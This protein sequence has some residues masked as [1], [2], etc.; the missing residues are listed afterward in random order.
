VQGRYSTQADQV[1]ED[2]Q[3]FIKHDFDDRLTLPLWIP[4][5]ITLGSV[6]Y[7]RNGRFVKLFDADFPPPDLPE[8]PQRT[9]GEFGLIETTIS[10]VDTRTLMER[11][12]DI[13]NGLVKFAKGGAE[14]SSVDEVG[15]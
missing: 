7:L 3:D 15:H 12:W 2:Y 9:I 5:V 6:G 13:V 10:P 4:S 8:P 14:T 1:Q 11:G